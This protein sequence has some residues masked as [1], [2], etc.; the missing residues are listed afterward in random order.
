[1]QA[2][3]MAWKVYGADGHRQRISFR[4]SFTLFSGD[5]IITVFN[6]DITGTNEYSIVTITAETINDCQNELNAQ[7]VDGI[8][9][10]S[11]YGKIVELIR[12]TK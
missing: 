1:M 9:E 7:L 3:V 8:F 4:E 2:T 12:V 6:S 5:N 10:N 11:K